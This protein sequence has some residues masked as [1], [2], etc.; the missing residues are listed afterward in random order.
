[1]QWL[2]T[3]MDFDALL[4][5]DVLRNNKN[6]VDNTD[7]HVYTLLSWCKCMAI[8][9][10]IYVSSGFV[11]HIWG[12][13]AET[14]AW[15]CQRWEGKREREG[16]WGL[17]HH[18]RAC[19]V[20]M[21]PHGNFGVQCMQSRLLACMVLLWCDL[22]EHRLSSHTGMFGK[23]FQLQSSLLKG[24]S[25]VSRR[26]THDQ[27]VSCLHMRCNRQANRNQKHRRF[28]RG[29]ITHEAALTNQVECDAPS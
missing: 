24:S 16:K 21:R 6:C 14:P 18:A 29:R 10:S 17:A 7:L 28:S 1:M 2:S 25:A 15:C 20:F 11:S 5:A 3:G 12:C 8:S 27:H 23:A 13:R 22:H 26:T 9:D 19:K 4:L